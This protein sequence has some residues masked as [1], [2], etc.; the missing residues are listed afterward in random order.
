[1]KRVLYIEDNHAMQKVV[2]RHLEGLAEM[3]M[4]ASL[5]EA[6]LTLRDHKFDLLLADV[7]LPDGNSLDLVWE[8]RR[9]YSADQLPI[10]MVSASMDR[11]LTVQ[12]LHVGANDCFAMPIHMTVL[13][14]AVARMLDRPYVRPNDLG[15]RVV[16]WVE[17]T[18]GDLFWVYCPELNLRLDGEHSEAV[19]EAM[20]Q[21][22]QSSV[23]TGAVLPFVGSVKA[24][25]RL[26]EISGP[27]G[28]IDPPGATGGPVNS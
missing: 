6:R 19:R 8:L 13:V 3:R 12:S 27:G 18:S 25:E 21:R 15:S 10:I 11:P 24:T 4:A 7:H 17:G 22:V 16:N 28:A 1:M 5:N 9:R 2:E 20:I 23:A 26:V 14:A